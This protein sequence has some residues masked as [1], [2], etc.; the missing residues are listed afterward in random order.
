MENIRNRFFWICCIVLCNSVHASSDGKECASLYNRLN[1]FEEESSNIIPPAFNKIYF[2]RNEYEK[3]ADYNKRIRDEEDKILSKAAK[4][5]ETIGNPAG[6]VKFKYNYESSNIKYN[7]DVEI[8]KLSRPMG[9]GTLT[10]NSEIPKGLR[11]GFNL[12][13]T[14]T[15]EPWRLGAKKRHVKSFGFLYTTKLKNRYLLGK[16]NELEIKMPPKMAE[17][18][19]KSISLVVV[20]KLVSPYKLE[21]YSSSDDLNTLTRTESLG[22]NVIIDLQCAAV[23]RSGTGE[24]LVNL[25]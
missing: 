1:V 22:T 23:F 16:S 13:F 18:I 14:S 17:A 11:S 2:P 5:V 7:A 25:N 4:A 12:K 8:L 3:A 19:G 21:M 20:G 10:S 15:E 6:F 24:V 9:F